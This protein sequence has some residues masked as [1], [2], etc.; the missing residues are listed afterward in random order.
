MNHRNGLL[1][2][3]SA[4]LWGAIRIAKKDAKIY[5][6]KPPV[7]MFGL[8]FPGF[9]YL[10]F[11]VGR[12]IEPTSLIPGLTAITAFFAAGSI[13]PAVLPLERK[14][15]TLER[16]LGAPL[17]PFS[18]ILGKTFAGAA[19]GLEMS[20]AP[21][22][23]GVLALGMPI[24]HLWLLIPSIALCALVFAAF[25]ILFSARADEMPNAM[26]PMNLVRFPMLF[27]SGVFVPLEAMAGFLRPIAYLMPL[28]YAVDAMR[29]SVLGP[30]DPM[31]LPADLGALSLFLAL[32]LALATRALRKDTD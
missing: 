27:V 1:K 19:F 28:T 25:G 12:A 17:S 8:V 29:Q 20:L 30:L 18:I 9:T 23:V 5:Y 32:F 7:I 11:T 3:A 16:L 6:L 4:E 31:M 15:N 2:R 14:T 24:A 26:M 10:A 22:L 21:L 13:G